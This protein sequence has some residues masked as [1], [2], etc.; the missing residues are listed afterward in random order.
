[1]ECEICDRRS[2]ELYET[3]VQGAVLVLCK[4]CSKFGEVIREVKAR[5]PE[6][7]QKRPAGPEESLLPGYGRVIRQA[8]EKAGM[9]QE[10]LGKKMN[11]PASLIK[12]AENENILLTKALEKKLERTLGVRLSGEVQEIVK[13]S[14]KEMP[15]TLGDIIKVKKAKK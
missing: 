13:S 14:T 8:R 15:L 12:R 2:D 10:E 1:M 11:E 5:K 4:E 6:E 3:R 9:T 7:R